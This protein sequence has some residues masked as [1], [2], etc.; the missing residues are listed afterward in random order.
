MRIKQWLH[1]AWHRLF[2]IRQKESEPILVKNA[3]LYD[4]AF[5]PYRKQGMKIDVISR[6]L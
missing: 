4:Q 3:E 1:N 5:Q 6:R 2:C